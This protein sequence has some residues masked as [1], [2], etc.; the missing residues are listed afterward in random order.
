MNNLTRLG[1]PRPMRLVIAAVALAAALAWIA[2]GQGHAAKALMA[3]V[4]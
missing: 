3:C 2:A 1:T 4:P